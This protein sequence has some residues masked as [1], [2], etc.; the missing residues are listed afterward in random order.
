MC[1]RDRMSTLTPGNSGSKKVEFVLARNTAQEVKEY[2]KMV[3]SN[4]KIP[5]SAEKK[6]VQGVLKSTPV[7]SPINPF[8]K[9]GDS[10]KRFLNSF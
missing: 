9:L 7:S 10:F 2:K 4:S 3:K 6:P 1:I 8:Y 5:F